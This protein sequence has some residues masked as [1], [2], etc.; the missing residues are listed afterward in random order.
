MTCAHLNRDEIVTSAAAANAALEPASGLAAQGRPEPQE[1]GLGL[2][3]S[4]RRASR[5]GAIGVTR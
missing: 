4:A 2:G 1:V 5:T 3:V